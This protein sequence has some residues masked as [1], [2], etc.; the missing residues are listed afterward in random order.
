MSLFLSN[1]IKTTIFILSLFQPEVLM[2]ILDSFFGPPV[3][4]LQPAEAQEKFKAPNRPYV[5]DVREPDEFRQAHIQGATLIPI[6]SL[7]ASL[8]KLPKNRDIVVV[9]ASG[10]RSISATRL[11]IGAGY[12]ALNLRGGMGMWMRAGL[13]VQRGK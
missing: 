7:Q 3:P 8:G 13:P 12:S 1:S 11:L 6:G 2:S 9:C 4:Q 5:L 10:S